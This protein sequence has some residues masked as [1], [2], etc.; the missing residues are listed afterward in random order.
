M[1]PL[2]Q[3]AL[4]LDWAIERL[5]LDD[6]DRCGTCGSPLYTNGTCPLCDRGAL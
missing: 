4:D 6:T 1:T 2:W 3:V 5:L